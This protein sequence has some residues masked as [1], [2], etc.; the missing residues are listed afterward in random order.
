MLENTMG[1]DEWT[2]LMIA[3]GEGHVDV[4]NVLLQHGASLHLNKV[5]IQMFCIKFKR[6]WNRS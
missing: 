5:K 4:V 2:P 1:Q 3:S 6:H